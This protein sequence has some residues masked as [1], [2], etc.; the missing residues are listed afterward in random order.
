MP[1][2]PI[3][4][5]AELVLG[6]VVTSKLE[7]PLEELDHGI[8]GALLVIGRTSALPPNLRLIRHP[9]SQLPQ[10]PRLADAGLP[11]QQRHLTEAVL[12]LL[13]ALQQQ[14]HLLA[15]SHECGET[16]ARR[17]ETSRDSF[18][19]VED[20]VYPERHRD[21]LRRLET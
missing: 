13:P 16:C 2:Q 17:L 1:P 14:P 20:A 12:H 7:R 5:L 8:E 3:F 18:S 19:F 21:A 4:D 11:A 9:L 15:S 10:Q 6:L